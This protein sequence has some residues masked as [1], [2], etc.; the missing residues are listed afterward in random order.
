MA[1]DIWH[2]TDPQSAA[3]ASALVHPLQVPPHAPT[4]ETAA[5]STLLSLLSSRYFCPDALSW[6]VVGASCLD[7]AAPD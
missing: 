6:E 5:H 2:L 7:S 4:G 3:M 1:L